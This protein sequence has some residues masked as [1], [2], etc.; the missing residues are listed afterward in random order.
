MLLSGGLCIGVCDP[1]IGTR[2]LE[3]KTNLCKGRAKTMQATLTEFH[4]WLKDQ[5]WKS[6]QH[7]FEGVFYRD[8]KRRYTGYNS[9]FGLCFKPFRHDAKTEVLLV[10][11]YVEYLRAIG[12]D[13]PV[14][15]KD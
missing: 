12:F 13:D 4:K 7:K 3:R 14:Q 1:V 6:I 5:E 10:S 8:Y 11:L 15:I 9:I 2:T